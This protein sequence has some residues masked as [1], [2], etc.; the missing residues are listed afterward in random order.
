MPHFKIE[1]SLYEPVTIEV[2]GGRVFESVPISTSLLR[3]ITRL[4][5]QVNAKAM[6]PE[7]ALIKQVALIFGADE[8]ELESLDF[9][10]LS[11]I[12]EYAN[13]AMVQDRGEKAGEQKEAEA[14]KN[15]PEPGGEISQS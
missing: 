7:A 5:E 2:E 15:G 6:D 4:D 10:V 14:E 1:K 9:R 8:K 3:D 11:R 12:L 13:E